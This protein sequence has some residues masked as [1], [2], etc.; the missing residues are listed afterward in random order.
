MTIIFGNKKVS[1]LLKGKKASQKIYAV[2]APKNIP[3]IT[4]E[5][6]K[7]IDSN[8]LELVVRKEGF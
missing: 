3:L 2:E 7:L 4:N 1:L 6:E 5:D 8:D